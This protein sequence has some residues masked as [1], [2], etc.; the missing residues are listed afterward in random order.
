MNQLPFGQRFARTLREIVARFADDERDLAAAGLAYYML[1][2]IAPLGV[3]AI[4]VA[5]AVFDPVVVR[6]ALVEDLGRA[7]GHQVSTLLAELMETQQE[8]QSGG[9]TL[10]SGVLL[11]VA[12]SRLFHRLQAA[13][14]LT[15][16]VRADPQIRTREALRLMVRKRVI[17]FLM[18]LGSGTALLVSLLIKAMIALMQTP[19]RWVFHSE[20]L[21]S[22]GMVQAEETLVSFLL[23]TSLVAGMFRVLPDVR[24]AWRD[25]WV[26]ATLTSIL[27]VL[28]MGGFSLYVSTFGATQLAGAIGSIAVLMLWAYYTSHVLLLGALFTRVWADGPVLQPHA[29]SLSSDLRDI[30]SLPIEGREDPRPSSTQPISNPGKK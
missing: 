1:L 29:I 7:T 6:Q 17:S 14:N 28:G 5:A 21:L 9:I 24:I 26:G 22:P 23:M 12:A 20:R 19:L 13:L 3:V 27:L 8:H 15:W 2:S 16:G 10:L 30:P 11:L 4:Q 18:V 25:V